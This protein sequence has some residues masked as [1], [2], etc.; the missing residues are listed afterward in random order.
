PPAF[1]QVDQDIDERLKLFGQH[2]RP[3]I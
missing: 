1:D 3:L 2:Q